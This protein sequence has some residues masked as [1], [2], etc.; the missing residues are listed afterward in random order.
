M[1]SSACKNKKITLRSVFL[2]MKCA[3]QAMLETGGGA[4]VNMSS[5]ACIEFFCF[6][7]IR[8]PPRSTLF[9]YTTLF[10]S[11]SDR[12]HLRHRR[13][14]QAD[15]PRPAL[16]RR[17]ARAGRALVR[18]ARGRSVLVHGGERLVEVSPKR[19]HRAL[20]ARGHRAAPRR[21]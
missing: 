1:P 4:I 5:P 14:A 20:G 15:P 18:G 8:R 2:S 21:A 16:P 11:R 9:P 19:V 6:L 13:R 3:L 10:R 7:M 12:L 17:P